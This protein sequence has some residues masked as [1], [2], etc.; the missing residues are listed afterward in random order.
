MDV[1]APLD[2]IVETMAGETI[3][4][5]VN[6]AL[7]DVEKHIGI[8]PRILHLKE[9]IQEKTGIEAQHQEICF[10]DTVMFGWASLTVCGL[11]HK[12]VVH[13]VQVQP[14]PAQ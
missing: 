1:V 3:T 12:S 7:S 6:R 13:L 10:K 14:K 9:M 2:I 4:L 8:V 11:E 5:D